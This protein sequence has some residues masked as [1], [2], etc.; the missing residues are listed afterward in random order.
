MNLTG[1]TLPSPCQGEGPG[2]RVFAA[3]NSLE[4][5]IE[6][7]THQNLETHERLVKKKTS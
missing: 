7:K 4:K 3:I 1:S 2:V 6:H 5:T